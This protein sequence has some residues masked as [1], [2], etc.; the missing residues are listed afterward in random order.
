MAIRFF[1][2]DAGRIASVNSTNLSLNL[3]LN[4]IQLGVGKTN[5]SEN[6]ASMTELINAVEVHELSGGAVDEASKELRLHAYIDS[7]VTADIYEVGLFTDTGVLFAYASTTNNTPILRLAANMVSILSIGVSLIDVQAS[8]VTVDVGGNAPMAVALMNA[9]LA[10]ENPHPQYATINRLNGAIQEHL[11]EE[12]PH[13]QYMRKDE[14]AVGDLFKFLIATPEEAAPHPLVYK[15]NGRTSGLAVQHT[16]QLVS[17]NILPNGV[18]NQTLKFRATKG[19]LTVHL[20]LPISVKHILSMTVGYQSAGMG[21]EDDDSDVRLLGVYDEKTTSETGMTESRTVIK[22]RLDAFNSGS[23]GTRERIGYLTV[24][25]QGASTTAMAD[26]SQ[27]PFPRYGDE[28][29]GSVIVISANRKDINLYELYLAQ[30]GAPTALTEVTFIVKAGVLVYGSDTEYGIRAGNWPAG[31]I[32]KIVNYGEIYGRGGDGGYFDGDNHIV[33]DGGTAIYTDD[34]TLI[35][36]DNYG[37]IA[38][39][40]GGGAAAKGEYSAGGV[41][42]INVVGGG[43]GAPYGLAKEPINQI[44]PNGETLKVFAGYAGAKLLGGS[45]VPAVEVSG[46]VGGDI[47][48]SGADS[49]G[50]LIAGVGGQA[51]KAYEGAVVVNNINAGTTKGR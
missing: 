40:G 26:L 34:E 49:T 8:N 6:A 33:G 28:Y 1:I 4:T 20:Y 19:D 2:T 51:G 11:R 16:V 30:Y 5:A 38:G 32:R 10:E 39:G 45:V 44:A 24:Q 22:A 41:N 50:N 7:S 3:N 17:A 12:D 31:S 36:V 47:G 42:Y 37:T 27:Y 48:V 29:S 35:M 23:N 43:G 13:P 14:F 25:G 46:G 15:A 21:N 18:I 9:H